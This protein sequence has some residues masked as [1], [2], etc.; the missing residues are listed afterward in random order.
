MEARRRAGIDGRALM[1]QST[2][3]KRVCEGLLSGHYSDGDT[4]RFRPIVDSILNGDWFL[5]G[6]DFDAY[7]RPR[8][9][10]LPSGQSRTI[11]RSLRS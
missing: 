10:S 9:T 11:G 1:E 4:M 2:A 8:P 5:V 3:L 6:S 7:A